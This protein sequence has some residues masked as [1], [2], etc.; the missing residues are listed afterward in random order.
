MRDIKVDKINSLQMLD[1]NTLEPIIEF[2]DISGMTI[3]TEIEPSSLSKEVLQFNHCAFFECELTNCSSFINYITDLN[4]KAFYIEYD[5]PIMIQSRWHKKYRINKKWLKRYGMKKDNVSVRCDVDSISPDK[6]YD[7]YNL[8]ESKGF[9]LELSNMR[10]KFRP[11][12][13]RRNLKI[14]RCYDKYD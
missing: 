10:Y 1:T 2:D 4:D 13:M 14:E 8:I 7:P 5:I 3:E 11:D 6:S 9:N 12:Q